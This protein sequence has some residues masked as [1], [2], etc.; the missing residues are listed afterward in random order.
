MKIDENE[1]TTY[2]HAIVMRAKET[3]EEINEKLK[4]KTVD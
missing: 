1:R 4:D 3:Y 2:T